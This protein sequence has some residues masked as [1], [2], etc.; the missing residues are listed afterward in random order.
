MPCHE[1]SQDV[2]LKTQYVGLIYSNLSLPTIL[3]IFCFLALLGYSL[4][5]SNVWV[6]SLE[7]IGPIPYRVDSEVP[8]TQS[9]YRFLSKQVYDLCSLPQDS[10]SND[11]HRASRIAIDKENFLCLWYSPINFWNV[12]KH[13]VGIS[14]FIVIIS[15]VKARQQ[16]LYLL[17]K[18]YFSRFQQARIVG[19]WGIPAPVS[20]RPIK[21]PEE[22]FLLNSIAPR[23]KERGV[24]RL[25]R[26]KLYLAIHLI[27][28]PSHRWNLVHLESFA[29]HEKIKTQFFEDPMWTDLAPLFLI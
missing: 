22:L 15:K 1:R 17:S 29:C 19:A 23:K 10:A 12:N 18:K 4:F 8:T 14:T 11:T 20:Y 16:P 7:I 26:F 9:T 28:T 5:P 6:E 13:S 21:R 27:T 2:F 24:F 25:Q 3:Q